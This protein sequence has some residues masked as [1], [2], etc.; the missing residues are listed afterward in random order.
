M[1]VWAIADLHL[2]FG[3]PQKSMEVFGE[4]WHDYAAKIESHW[5]ALVKQEDLV[6]LAGDIS[7]AMK[8][9]DAKKDLDW[10][11]ALPGTKVMIKGN[12]D[13]WWSSLSK[14]TPILPPSIHLI[15]NNSFLFHQIAIAGARLWDSDEYNF[16]SLIN[17]KEPPTAIARRE[18]LDQEKIFKRELERLELSLK[19]I[20]TTAT[21]R[22]AMTHY[23]P[24]GNDLQ[25]SQAASLLERYSISH[26]VFGHLHSVKK[27]TPLFGT[28]RGTT[29]S[30]TSADYLNFQPLKILSC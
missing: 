7:W 22:L 24:I 8:V 3:V 28:A 20:P 27:G 29:Y 23:P 16:N 26:C 5:S 4:E 6:L 15:Q 13:Y 1:N 2:A 18:T 10:I 14:I 17:F 19:A 12:H 21:I 25:P 30:L 9:E 11:G